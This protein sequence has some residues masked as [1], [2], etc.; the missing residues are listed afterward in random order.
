MSRGQKQVIQECTKNKKTGVLPLR[1]GTAAELQDFFAGKMPNAKASGGTYERLT[2]RTAEMLQKDLQEAGLDYIDSGGRYFDFHSL[3]GEC[4]TLLAASGV[5][6]KTAQAIMRHSD[7]NLT[8]NAYTHTL[9]GQEAQAIESLPDLSLPDREMQK[10]TGT[11]DL[12]VDSAYKPAYK[13]LTKNAYLDSD[14]LSVD[15]I[16]ESQEVCHSGENADSGKVL[17][18]RQIGTDEDNMSPT[19]K[20]QKSNGRCRTR[21]CDRL[22]K[23][24]LLYRLS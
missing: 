7:I 19:V 16:A 21:T 4:A 15:S 10:A 9:R 3:R 14:R 12:P 18:D 2:D 22:I 23:S 6:P 1:A 20:G 5:H 8:M 11:D 17:S 24:Q 13:K